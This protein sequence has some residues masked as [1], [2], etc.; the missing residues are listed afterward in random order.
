VINFNDLIFV[1]PKKYSF[2]GLLKYEGELR[3]YLPKGFENYISAFNDF[4]AKRDVF[5]FYIKLW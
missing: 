3:F 2:V 5:F 4:E 1:I